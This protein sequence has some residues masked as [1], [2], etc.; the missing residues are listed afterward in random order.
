MKNMAK[1]LLSLGLIAV[2]AV[3]AIGCGGNTNKNQ[4]E[5]TDAGTEHTENKTFDGEALKIAVS[6]WNPCMFLNLAE[7]LGYFEDMGV[8]VELVNFQEYTDVPSAFAAGH[9]DGAFYSSFEVLVPAST[10]TELK[11]VAVLDRSNGADAILAASD[12]HTMEDLKGKNIGLGYGTIDYYYFMLEAEK[13]GYTEADFN[14]IDM[15][16]STVAN[17]IVTGQVDATAIF[18]PFVSSIQEGME[19]NIITDTTQNPDMITDCLAF[20][21]SAIASRK[22]DISK[23]MAAYYKAIAYY[24]ENREEA[25]AIMAEAMGDTTENFLATMEKLKM[26]TPQESDDFLSGNNGSWVDD[27]TTMVEYLLKAGELMNDVDV[28]TIV[29]TSIVKEAIQLMEE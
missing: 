16:P 15:N 28:S 6:A 8:E 22:E 27:Q 7:K 1:R 23:V 10:G 13:A 11:V 25:A 14:I 24:E 18:E 2:M 29:D 26:L 19:A 17:A 5:N 9:L 20:S 12:Y 21:D 4:S 3:S